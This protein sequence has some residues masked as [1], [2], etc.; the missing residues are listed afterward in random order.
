MDSVRKRNETCLHA[1]YEYN[2]YRADGFSIDL[3][4][5]K[6][7]GS[8]STTIY[9][10][11]KSFRFETCVNLFAC[12]IGKGAPRVVPWNTFKNSPP[13]RIAGKLVR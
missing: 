1:A 2:W 10:E 9:W 13:K 8:T 12:I 4:M 7:D 11:G 6:V 3:T 5:Y